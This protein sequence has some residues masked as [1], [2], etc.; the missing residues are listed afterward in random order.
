MIRKDYLLRQINQIIEGLIRKFSKIISGNTPYNPQEIND[1]YI[2][3]LGMN[4]LFFT[5]HSTKEIAIYLLENYDKEEAFARMRILSELLY[6]EAEKLKD[7]LMKD[8]AISILQ[9]VDKH[10]GIFDLDRNRRLVEMKKTME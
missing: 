9:Y 6:G 4:R 2:K 5:N 8:K 3:Y 10:S 1:M 7:K